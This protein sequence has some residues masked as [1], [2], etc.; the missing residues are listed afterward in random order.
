MNTKQTGETYTSHPIVALRLAIDRWIQTNVTVSIAL[1]A[2]MVAA[3]IIP[4]VTLS[5]ALYI[6]S[7]PT[8][9][10]VVDLNPSVIA[11]LGLLIFLA[12]VAV[13]A[14]LAIALDYSFI[15][16]QN[17]KKVDYKTAVKRGYKRL[18]PAIG[19]YILALLAIIVGLILLIIP[20]IYLALRL[21][22]L[23]SVVANEDLGPVATIKRAFALSKNNL[24]DI[25]G[26][27]SA[28]VLVSS[29][30]SIATNATLAAT[31]D[32]IF[33]VT[34]VLLLTVIS[35]AAGLLLAQALYFRYHQSSLE[36]TG[37]LTKTGTDKVNYWL[38]VGALVATSIDSSLNQAQNPQYNDFNDFNI[39]DYTDS[40]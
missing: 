27:V 32:N 28:S 36:K 4:I 24:W 13:V 21:S 9:T 11:G 22:Y 33:S 6:N 15:S 29:L 19:T 38:F 5:S 3:L 16:S 39:E 12:V 18:L 37:E 1:I 14:P 17:G 34:L 26:V 30:F 20:G 25:V 7:S 31:P 8:N 2:T 23:N 40:V 35:I 10:S